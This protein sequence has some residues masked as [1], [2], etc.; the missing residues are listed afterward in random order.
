MITDYNTISFK[1]KR[2][3]A[4]QRRID[5]LLEVLP[6]FCAEYEK[7]MH[8]RTVIKTRMEYLQDINTFFRYLCQKNSLIKVMRTDITPQLLEKL[9]GDV[10]DEYNIWLSNYTL[11]GEHI[12]NSNV[13]IRR[14]YAGLKSLFHYLYVREIISCNP[15]EKAVM[16]TV[17]Q[18]RRKDIRILED[19]EYHLFLNTIENA[20]T[21]S[22][23]RSKLPD[24]SERDRIRPSLILRDKA[25]IYL[26]L[27]TG[28]R[29]SELCAID[30]S[31]ISFQ[32]GYIN[33]IRKEDSDDA[34]T[35][36]RVYMNPQVA[37]LLSDYINTARDIIGPGM[38]NYDAL[39]ISSKHTRITPR[40][41][42][43]IIKDYADKALGTGNGITPHKLRA[44]F[45]TRYQ[46]EFGDI[47]ATQSVM[48]HSDVSITAKYYLQEDKEAKERV[49][50]M[51]I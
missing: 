10:F 50:D 49:R 13:T 40:A 9:K 47:S 51:K 43:L 15:T 12:H 35:T 8:S 45:G 7:F 17:R 16:P 22:V 27:G 5:D 31:N 11:K 38:D 42:E 18:K 20:Y 6:E 41:V 26:F 19:D 34:T 2:A 28:L 4:C 44:T 39:F 37:T 46:R 14:K 32:L 1:E 24:A 33:V 29:V 25:I 30:C 21:E 48:N 3:D 23:E 36:D